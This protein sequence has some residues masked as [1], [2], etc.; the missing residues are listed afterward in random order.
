MSIL[1]KIGPKN[2]NL[3]AILEKFEK[4]IEKV[5]DVLTIEHKTLEQ[6]N[7]ENASWHYFFASRKAELSTL[8]KYFEAEVESVRGNLFKTLTKTN[9]RDM[10]DRAKDKFID[11]EEAY[12]TAYELYLEVKEV[13]DKYTSVVEAFVVR[14]YALNNI[15]KARVAEVHNMVI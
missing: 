6:A 15:T 14:G 5:F 13:Y 4:D 3:G 10:S 8:V 7:R 9:Q 1:S 2:E 11:S 12:L